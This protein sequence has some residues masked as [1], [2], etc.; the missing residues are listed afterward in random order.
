MFLPRHPRPFQSMS[1]RQRAFRYFQEPVARERALLFP[2]GVSGL[3]ASPIGG[4]LSRG[5]SIYSRGETHPSLGLNSRRVG[6]SAR[7]E[8]SGEVHLRK[9]RK[10]AAHFAISEITILF[11]AAKSQNGIRITEHRNLTYSRVPSHP[12]PPSLRSLAA[13][14]IALDFLLRQN[15]A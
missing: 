7:D 9:R 4:L 8:T 12:P 3:D 14:I 6:R 1:S 10:D 13:P 15:N 5:C 2:A 11:S